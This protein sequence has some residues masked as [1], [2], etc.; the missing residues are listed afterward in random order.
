M[1]LIKRNL[2]SSLIIINIVVNIIQSNKLIITPI[3]KIKNKKAIKSHIH[4]DIHLYFKSWIQCKYFI[5]RSN[6]ILK[7]H[8]KSSNKRTTY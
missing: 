7:K 5:K 8:P 4:T 3:I 6:I 1:Y 2:T